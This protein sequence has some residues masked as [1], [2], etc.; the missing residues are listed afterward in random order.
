MAP[1]IALSRLSISTLLLCLVSA[2]TIDVD[3]PT[4][5]ER[6]GETPVAAT[7]FVTPDTTTEEVLLEEVEADAAV[8]SNAVV[9]PDTATPAQSDTVLNERPLTPTEPEI[10][11]PD[12]NNDI[13]SAT[14]ADVNPGVNSGVPTNP[15]TN[16]DQA[17]D[18]GPSTITSSGT[19]PNSGSITVPSQPLDESGIA[20][21]ESALVELLETGHVIENNQIVPTTVWICS[22]VFDAKRNYYFYQAGV[23][24]PVRNVVIERTLN[25]GNAFDDIN[26]F[27]SVS[28][29]DSIILSSLAAG[30]DGVLVAS[31]QEYD[32]STI[33][34]TEVDSKPA[35]SAQSVLT[36]KLNCALFDV[37]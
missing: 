2:C 19:N 25:P 28:G 13:N 10:Q 32:V 17:Q 37:R 1:S 36:G 9:Q 27:W 31:G 14:N 5:S 22:D 21:S 4:E 15:A 20:I 29:T 33:R 12:Q 26:F 6:E 16:T 24:N 35:F 7:E 30:N 34:F 3:E 8:A 11:Q 18:P 23:I